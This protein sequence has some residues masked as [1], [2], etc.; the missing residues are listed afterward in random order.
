[1]KRFDDLEKIKAACVK[2]NPK[3]MELAFPCRLMWADCDWIVIA[4]C[5]KCKKHK[6]YKSCN[7]DC[8]FD[9][10]YELWTQDGGGDMPYSLTFTKAEVEKMYNLGR[11]VSLADVLLAMGKPV[12]YMTTSGLVGTIHKDVVRV[13]SLWDFRKDDLEQQSDETL[14]FISSL[15]QS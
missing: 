4:E 15:L 3:I 5:G 10:A 8:D 12:K 7:E 14:E 2:V 9:D 6:R 13:L 1:M 11:P